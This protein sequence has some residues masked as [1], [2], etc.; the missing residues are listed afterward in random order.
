[1]NCWLTSDASAG[2]FRVIFKSFTITLRTKWLHLPLVTRVKRT[3]QYGFV[4]PFARLVVGGGVP[5]Y[6]G[7]RV[8]IR[9]IQFVGVKISINGSKNLKKYVLGLEFKLTSIL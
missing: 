7:S 2:G 5:Q 9:V 3:D 1:M 8:L 6:E 4:T